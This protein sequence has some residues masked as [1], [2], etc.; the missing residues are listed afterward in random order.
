[1]HGAG[2]VVTD[3][4]T[5]A[6]TTNIPKLAP[7]ITLTMRFSAS[8]ISLVEAGVSYCARQ[9]LYDTEIRNIQLYFAKRQQTQK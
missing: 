1:L 2:I 4:I 6:L 3:I 7:S 8:G 9:C 5:A